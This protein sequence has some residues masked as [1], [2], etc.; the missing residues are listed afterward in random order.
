[1]A[2]SCIYCKGDST[3]TKGLAHVLAEGVSANQATLP[4]GAVCD[5]CNHY[6]GR[7]LDENLVRY[8][9]VALPIQILGIRGKKGKKRRVLGGVSRTPA[10]PGLAQL[11][12]TLVNARIAQAAPGRHA[13]EFDL[14]VDKDFDLRRFRRALH[15]TALNVIAFQDSVER[16]LEERFDLV[17]RYVRNPR[18]AND[19]WPYVQWD[20]R[21]PSIPRT[22]AG[23]GFEHQ[24]SVLVRMQLFGTV[25]MV[26]LLNT[27]VLEGI[28]ADRQGVYVPPG[29]SKPPAAV[30]AVDFRLK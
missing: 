7:R 19:S 24:G 22:F 10:K 1:M 12:A 17:R 4:R 15:H 13:I 14:K 3:A 8:P 11:H 29:Q 25:Y 18:P 26:D 5:G 27:G 20:L 9:A 16:A 21:L 28:A 2:L 30:I 6:L 23:F